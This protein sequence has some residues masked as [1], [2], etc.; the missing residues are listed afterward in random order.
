MA[1]TEPEI[2]LEMPPDAELEADFDP[3]EAPTRP[4]RQGAC[5]PRE[6]FRAL[7]SAVVTIEKCYSLSPDAFVQGQQILE[8]HRDTM[9]R[10][11]NLYGVKR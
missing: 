1:D 9:T 8:D 10:L 3:H 5:V 6:D 11:C 2:V 4:G 7:L